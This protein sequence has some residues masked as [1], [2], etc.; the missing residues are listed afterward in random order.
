VSF[1][2][3]VKNKFIPAA[4]QL[5]RNRKAEKEQREQEQEREEKERQ[6]Y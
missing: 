6:L 3:D 4:R 2:L 5:W 1:V